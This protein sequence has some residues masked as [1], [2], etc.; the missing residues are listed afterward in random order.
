MA[1]VLTPNGDFYDIVDNKAIIRPTGVDDWDNIQTV[2]NTP[3]LEEVRFS[4]GTFYVS[5]QL[6]LQDQ[7]CTVRGAGESATTIV[8]GTSTAPIRYLD[9]AD[10]ALYEPGGW[11][12]LFLVKESPGGGTWP[13]VIFRD[14]TAEGTSA[15]GY[16]GIVFH[17]IPHENIGIEA[18]FHLTPSH[19]HVMVLNVPLVMTGVIAQPTGKTNIT[20]LLLTSLPEGVGT[21]YAL[22]TDYTVDGVTGTVTRVPT[23]AILDGATVYAHF[24]NASE[25]GVNVSVARLIVEDVTIKAGVRVVNGLRYPN[26]NSSFAVYRGHGLVLADAAADSH[27]VVYLTEPEVAGL[28]WEDPVVQPGQPLN[29]HIELRRLKVYDT[30]Q[31]IWTAGL[32]G[33]PTDPGDHVFPANAFE[34][35]RVLVEDCE[36]LRVGYGAHG[37]YVLQCGHTTGTDTVFRRNSIT[38]TS[39][40]HLILEVRGSGVDPNSHLGATWD[41]ALDSVLIEDEVVRDW[42]HED[43]AWGSYQAICI[44]L[45]GISIF[46]GDATNQETLGMHILHNQIESTDP[47]C[48]MRAIRI[49]EQQRFSIIGN[50]V[51]SKRGGTGREAIKVHRCTG[52]EIRS[53][54]L[55]GYKALPGFAAIA[56]ASTATG[57]VVHA[58]DNDLIQD[59]AVGTILS[60]GTRSSLESGHNPDAL[61]EN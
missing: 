29:A 30:G 60:G 20:H 33:V 19:T 10:R 1:P 12:S 13:D 4:S 39:G 50:E 6:L 44:Q 3:G 54:K 52:G 55:K 8:W 28:W 22:T 42:K 32:D 45:F 26:C 57:I 34:R 21:R 31:M 7:Q 14:F 27:Q 37:D 11:P 46:G 15:P 41:G 43:A 40:S 25:Y 58:D 5:Y 38:T 48:T 35:S 18:A 61:W 47:T 51:V 17:G 36:T 56:V 2:F 23:G 24:N 9:A 49:S 59:L 53:N 16:T